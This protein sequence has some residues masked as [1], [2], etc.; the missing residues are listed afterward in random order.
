MFHKIKNVSA[1]SNYRLSVQFS[2]GTTKVYKFSK[3]FAD[4]NRKTFTFNGVR[5]FSM[6]GEEQSRI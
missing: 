5:Y 2:E 4:C 3:S 1:L 6:C